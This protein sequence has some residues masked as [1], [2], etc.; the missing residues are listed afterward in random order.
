MKQ[1]KNIHIQNGTPKN[2]YETG[3][4]VYLTNLHKE[5]N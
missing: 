5:N 4:K 1:D 2:L 3:K